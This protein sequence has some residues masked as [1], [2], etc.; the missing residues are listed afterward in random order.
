MVLKSEH[1]YKIRNFK[2]MEW[3]G[4]LLEFWLDPTLLKK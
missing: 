3:N 2:K 4:G 1:R